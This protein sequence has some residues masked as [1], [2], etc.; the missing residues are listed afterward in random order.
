MLFVIEVM[1]FVIDVN[2]FIIEVLWFLID[3]SSIVRVCTQSNAITD[4]L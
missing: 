3:T 4:G 2:K 1:L